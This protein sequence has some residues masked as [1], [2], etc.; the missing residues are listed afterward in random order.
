M[1]LSSLLNPGLLILR[2]P[3]KTKDA[4]IDALVREIYRTQRRI[5][6]PE[7]AVRKALAERESL[8][9]TVFP[10]GLAVPHARLEGFNDLLIAV[11][12]PAEPIP[13]PEN[14]IKMMILI[15]TTQA[16]GAVYLNTLGAFVKISQDHDL[17]GRLCA[18]QSPQSFIQTI[19]ERNIEVM[20]TLLIGSVMQRNFI[21]LSPNQTIKDAADIFYKNRVSYLPVLDETG[22][23]TGELT[24]LDLFA[25][26]FP[27]YALK[28][29]NLQF[30]RRLEPFEDLLTKE[31]SIFVRQAMKRPGLILE[32]HT[33]VVEGIMQFIRSNRRHIPVVQ[34]G[35][36]TG[37][38]S[39]IDILHKVLRA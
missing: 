36:L 33:P 10:S 21:S 31:H 29:E 16:A 34:R 12:V 3:A 15:L 27:D 8:G 1:K 2:T 7:Q 14:P 32:E 24:V 17:F 38:I 9:G 37:I 13:T 22:A 23:F 20:Q 30:L 25:L 18:A 39:Y 11:G 6:L 26:G 4:L 5:A 28:L 19:N 35:K